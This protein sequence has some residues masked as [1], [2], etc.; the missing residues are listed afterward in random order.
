MGEL[1]LFFLSFIFLLCLFASFLSFL[2]N[3]SLFMNKKY[4]AYL[5]SPEWAQVKIDIYA[6]RGRKCERCGSNAKLQVHHKSYKNIFN[7]EPKDLEILCDI[8]HKKEHGVNKKA[9]KVKLSPRFT[10]PKAKKQKKKKRF[11][12]NDVKTAR[13]QI[14]QSSKRRGFA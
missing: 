10:K 1:F 6:S 5:L 4:K 7:E 11:W 2:L 9:K 13:R 14:K 8:C 12:M 3:R